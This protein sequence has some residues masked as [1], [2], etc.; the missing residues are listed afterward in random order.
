MERI[1]LAGTNRGTQVSSLTSSGKAFGSEVSGVT[2][3]SAF[4]L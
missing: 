1:W 4:S 3:H 2:A